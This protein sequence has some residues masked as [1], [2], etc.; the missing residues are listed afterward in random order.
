MNDL[1]GRFGMWIIRSL[2]GVGS[3][4]TVLSKVSKYNIDLVGVQEVKWEGDSTKPAEECIF[5][6]GKG[7]KNHEL[8][9]GFLHISA[10]KSV[11][12]VSDKMLYITPRGP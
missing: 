10:V 1:S 9:T 12:F 6:H 11:E 5:L 8:G 3:Q 4:I 7:S 2:Y